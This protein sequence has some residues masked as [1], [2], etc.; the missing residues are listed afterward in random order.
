VVTGRESAK[1][2]MIFGSWRSFLFHSLG[3]FIMFLWLLCTVLVL[4]LLA[5][6]VLWGVVG[7]VGAGS[8]ERD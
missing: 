8:G 4:S 3:A 6:V 7:V 5:C 2:A 1:S